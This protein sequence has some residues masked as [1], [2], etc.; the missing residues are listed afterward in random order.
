M[1]TITALKSGGG[2]SGAIAKYYLNEE[3]HLQ[4]KD[5]E[6]MNKDSKQSEG[7]DPAKVI[8]DYGKYVLAEVKDR[9]NSEWFG[10]LADKLNLDGKAVTASKLTKIL[11]GKIDDKGVAHRSDGARRNG[12]DLTFSAPKGVSI[13][14]LVSGD[15]RILE[16][17]NK[18]VKTALSEAARIAPELRNKNKETDKVDR[19][20]TDNVMFA[21]ATHKTSRT[22][23]PELHTHALLANLTMDDKGKLRAISCEQLY[24]NSKYL[25]MVYQADLHKA[26][27]ELGYNTKSLGNGQYDLS[28]VPQ[29]LIEKFSTR[30]QEI[31][32][33]EAEL[34]YSSSKSRDI[35]ALAYR[36]D[37][38]Y[39]SDKDMSSQWHD[40][41]KGHDLAGI[42]EKAI[43][44]KNIPTNEVSNAQADKSILGAIN[45]LSQFQTKMDFNQV[46]QVAL[47]EFTINDSIN[48]NDL[49]KS[50]EDKVSNG[51]V[52]PLD[53]NATMLTSNDQI[54]SEESIQASIATEFKKMSVPVNAEALSEISINDQNKQT[55]KG[56]IEST[57]QANMLSVRGSSK[58]AL[59]SLIHVSENSGKNLTILTPNSFHMQDTKA[60]TQR[61]EFGL[62]QWVKNQF[63]DQDYVKTVGG[64]I[65]QNTFQPQL[66][67]D[68]LI[69]VDQADKLSLKETQKLLDITQNSKSK[70]ILMHQEA[71]RDRS[72]RAGNITETLKQ[73]NIQ[74]QQWQSEKMADIKVGLKEQVDDTQRFGEVAQHYASLSDIDKDK[75]Q[76]VTKSRV[77]ADINN[78][79]IRQALVK[80]G[81]LSEFSTQINVDRPR[82]LSV[83]KQDIA[84]N[85][86]MDDKLTFFTKDNGAKNYQVTGVD[87]ATN[88]VHTVSPEGV[89]SSFDPAKNKTNMAVSYKE[90]FE[91]SQG[92]QLF[93]RKSATRD[94]KSGES[95]QVAAYDKNNIK[96]T[97][98]DNKTHTVSREKIENSQL[99]YD[100][101]R[102][103]ADVSYDNKKD[104]LAN[105]KQYSLNKETITELM[106]KSS[107]SVN[108][109]TDDISKAEHKM[110]RSGVQQSAISGVITSSQ[111][112]NQLTRTVNENTIT[113]LKQDLTQA[114]DV[115]NSKYAKDG[116]QKSVDY[117]IGVLTD[118][119]AVFSHKDMVELAI[120]HSLSEHDKAISL[121]DVQEK[122]STMVKSGE[123]ISDNLKHGT[124][125]TTQEAI[126]TEKSILMMAKEGADTVAPLSDKDFAQKHLSGDQS[127]FQLSNGQ[128]EA[129]LA[130]TTTSDKYIA[131]QGY[132]GVGK[133]T[134]LE[135]GVDLVRSSEELLKTSGKD[136]PEF[137]GLGPTHGAVK[138]LIDKGI[139]AQTTKSLLQEHVGSTPGDEQS[140]EL[141]NRVYLLDESSMISNN[142]FKDFMQIV[143]KTNARAIFIGDFKQLQSLEAGHP[144]KLLIQSG[145]LKTT[146]VPEIQRQKDTNYLN[147]V[148]SLIN[149][150]PH[151]ANMFLKAQEGHDQIEYSQPSAQPRLD[152]NVRQIGNVP[153]MLR[154]VGKEYLSRTPEHRDKTL[155]VANSHKE[156]DAI[157][158]TIRSGLLKEGVLDRETTTS[159]P[160]LSNLNKSNNEMLAI[161]NYKKDM[162]MQ[163]GQHEFYNIDKV[164]RKN[165][166]LSLRSLTDNSVKSIVPSRM[167]HQFNGVFELEKKS[168]SVN[169]QVLM[170]HSDKA[171]G[172]VANEEYKITNID[173]DT[174][175]IKLSNDKKDIQMDAKDIKSMRWD[176]AYTKT[177]YASQGATYPFVISVDK[178]KSPLNNA[179]SDYVKKS[180]GSIHAMVFTDNSQNYTNQIAKNT[181]GNSIA[182]SI[183][184]DF[185]S[186]YKSPELPLNSDHSANKKAENNHTDT[187]SSKSKTESS[188][189]DNAA[190]TDV[191]YHDSNGMFDIR[192]YGKDVSDQ[193]KMYTEDVVKQYLGEPNKSKSSNQF[194]AYGKD[195]A[196][197]KVT[198][199]GQNR[200]K[201]VDWATGEK[202]DLITLIM[203]ET[204]MSYTESVKEGSKMVSMPESFSIKAVE[205]IITENTATKNRSKAFDYA[206]GL[207]DKGSDIKGT[208][209][210]TYL[211]DHR[212]LSQ[213]DSE[214]IRFNGQVFSNESATKYEPAFIAAFKNKSGEITAIEAQY[215]D[216]DTGNKS[217]LPTQKRGYGNKHGSAVTITEAKQS[218]NNI[219]LV[220]ESVITSLSVK[221]VYQEEHN[222]AVGGI[223]NL[224][225]IDPDMLK[226]NVIIC[227]DNDGL[228]VQINN[229][230]ETA[231]AHL[232]GHGKNVLVVAPDDINGLDKVDY[233]DVLNH[234]GVGEIKALLDDKITTLSALDQSDSPTHS[235][236]DSVV[237]DLLDQLKNQS[238]M[239]DVE[240]KDVES[241]IK[242]TGETKLENLLEHLNLTDNISHDS[243]TISE[244]NR[245]DMDEY[246]KNFKDE[247]VIDIDTKSH[248]H[249]RDELVK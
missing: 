126:D 18:A 196:S 39:I 150:K 65:A 116:I 33:K 164:D 121:T 128:K 249:E 97:D 181:A 147:A 168:I 202:G 90:Q 113:A 212:G 14:A 239:S 110:R 96:L 29:S 148:K 248:N 241:F 40:K 79:Y 230:I 2:G 64:F 133:S 57:K 246:L 70:I 76:I 175:L 114:L 35:I 206:K 22:L 185:N 217:T 107:E 145:T 240:L 187:Q 173:K 63:K 227:A 15:K 204:G 108:I 69:V 11:D 17:H 140:K 67:N 104:I 28:D 130:I 157:T 178:S 122:L 215:I 1:L 37:K 166:T 222:L 92:D 71:G 137:I 26:M 221:E 81:Q 243:A 162:V 224:I 59:S 3:K 86:K 112:D 234:Q 231:V 78:R 205:N 154:E 6:L 158:R 94:L 66:S 30:R 152:M 111:I 244:L 42:A 19:I 216:R 214:N 236:Q 83:D 52:I 85:Y 247:V 155:I 223:G 225:N 143:E 10:P 160:R 49:K 100:Y 125:W 20:K 232:E 54:K 88:T 183:T 98:A 153:D 167:S 75:L 163:I 61:Q 127:Q 135:K 82:Y 77:D 193:L 151:L 146:Y 106:Q 136:K 142:D 109:Y 194:Y 93:I 47:S 188:L 38:K 226:D 115:L 72:G 105:F 161:S 32:A 43:N 170:K 229:Q 213:V 210:E 165:K 141:S 101:A 60:N 124:L 84:K 123:I 117:A 159:V 171:Q 238:F 53:G 12:Y 198:L 25:G 87:K 91:I 177:T 195:S 118:R 102:T 103:L 180:R 237:E 62:F 95:Y 211:R 149:E 4:I 120:T 138:E 207:W 233:N 179:L 51:I 58:E 27:I 55:V 129:V 182:L 7:L 174:G 235:I 23:D 21:L 34:G 169:D 89:K 9:Q 189:P 192:L 46:L 203:R 201:W 132:A 218:L 172:I 228:N 190:N 199:T 16:A 41:S 219:S 220:S 242:E 68:N 48:I 139:N 144:F 176:Y 74:Q 156:R 44:N 5:T 134:M 119:Q 131:I 8:K 186:Y 31:L 209:A 13:M 24:N 56:L 73:A 80:S 208:L 184:G 36:D 245:N 50:L 99:S 197:L 200:G 45:H 191:K